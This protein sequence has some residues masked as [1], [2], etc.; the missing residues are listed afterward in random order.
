MALLEETA[1]RQVLKVALPSLADLSARKLQQGASDWQVRSGKL[2]QAPY[3]PQIAHALAAV[4]TEIQT[5]SIMH[6]LATSL[7][8]RTV[9][10]PML[11]ALKSSAGT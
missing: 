2:R 10:A 6:H 11:W 8:H 7:R 5:L 4:L 3:T 1:A 9:R